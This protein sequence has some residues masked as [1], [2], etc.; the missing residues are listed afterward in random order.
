[1]NLKRPRREARTS[2]GRSS[3]RVVKLPEERQRRPADRAAIRTSPS[4]AGPH[5]LSNAV[6][7]KAKRS[8]KGS[9]RCDLYF[10]ATNIAKVQKRNEASRVRGIAI[11][12]FRRRASQKYKSKTKYQGLAALPF[13]L[14]GDEQRKSTKAK[15][16]IKGLRHCHL[17][18]LPTNVT[19][20]V[21]NT[22]LQPPAERS[23][24]GFGD[25]VLV[26]L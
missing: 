3:S 22:R 13:V 1:M 4:P 6:K 8:I 2:G 10:S 24:K 21:A 12:T 15:R 18:Y 7:P 19:N 26:F 25:H 16:S 14:F 17:Y 11:C 23:I 20:E 9:R 5:R